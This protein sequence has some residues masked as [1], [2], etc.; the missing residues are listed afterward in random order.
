MAIPQITKNIE[1]AASIIRNSEYVQFKDPDPASTGIINY[2][3]EVKYSI[4]NSHNEQDS[5]LLQNVEVLVEACEN[6]EK[7]E[8]SEES[9]FKVMKCKVEYINI[10]VVSEC[11]NDA[12][13][14]LITDSYQEFLIAT[15]DI[16]SHKYILNILRNTIFAHVAIPFTFKYD[17]V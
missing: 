11:D 9:E 16:L 12:D 1:L 2:H 7:K 6:N 4:R 17:E 13:I 15:S 3:I 8:S 10:Y 5:E 14:S